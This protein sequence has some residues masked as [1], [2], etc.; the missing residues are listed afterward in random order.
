MDST[1]CAQASRVPTLQTGRLILERIVPRDAA[2]MYAYAKSEN[3]TRYLLWEPHKSLHHTKRYIE[4]LQE[5]YESGEFFDWGVHLKESGQ[6]IGT[7][8]FA[9]IHET[10]RSAEIGYVLSERHWG[11]GYA[12]EAARRVMEYGFRELLLSKI[13]ARYMYGNDASAAVMAKCGM[14][15]LGFLPEQLYV[16]GGYRTVRQAEIRRDEWLGANR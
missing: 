15:D 10:E 12:S 14:R 9:A 1:L 13:Y 3:V 7:C 16:K 11:K 8:G 2:E 4:L 5:K 6:F